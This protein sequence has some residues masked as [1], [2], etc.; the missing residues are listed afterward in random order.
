M[1]RKKEVKYIF[2]TGGVVSSLGKGIA[3]ASIGL[4]LKQRGLKVSIL[5]LDPYLNLDPGTM[6]PY[7]HGE[8]YVTEDGAETD[9]DLGHY[10]R[11]IDTNMG[12]INNATSGQIY[13]SVLSKERKGDYLGGTV[14]VI[15]H[16][17][18]EIK[19]RITRVVS[20]N[21][22]DVL[23]VEIGGTVGDIEGLPFIEAIRQFKH[24]VGSSNVLYIHLT[25][26]PYVAAAGELKT[27]P[28]Q[29]SVKDLLKL[30]IQPDIL[31]TRTEKTISKEAKEKIALFCNVDKNCVIE[32]KD[33]CTIYQVPVEFYNH[34]L[35]AI[36]CDKLMI[37]PKK[38]IDLENWKKIVKN[39]KS[40]VKKIKIAVVGKYVGLHDSYK[41]IIESFI[42]A[43]SEFKAE[44]EIKWVNSEELEHNGPSD[45]LSNVA[46]ILVPGGFGDRGIEGKLLAVKYARENKVPFFGI[47]LGMQCA[48]IE[49]ARN[50]GG[51][52][53]ANSTEFARKLKYPVI[54]LMAEQKK[55]KNKGGTMRLGAFTCETVR[56]TKLYKAYRKNKISERHRHRFEV[57]NNFIGSLEDCGLLVSGKNP[58]L[59]LVEAIELENHPWFVGV[60]YHPELKSR[61]TKAHPLFRDFVKA[62]LDFS[63]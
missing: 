49:F 35:D 51:M 3:A 39:I 58:D 1:A 16:I 37:Q 12:K 24:D 50:V 30:G 40:P 13:E 25:Y 29:H 22:L 28:T 17:T 60:Q 61:L 5:K 10:E 56:G 32:A 19:E 43:G 23:F 57:N 4:L 47:C 52:K 11:F 8:V 6:S 45:T 7:Q 20:E 59:N 44:V 26:L 33:Q 54:D 31:I 55:V 48:V 21:K 27:K 38:K 53:N 46:G 18:D 34:K 36:I 41:S 2:V 42:H 62:A 15:P 9:L 14:Q 63:K